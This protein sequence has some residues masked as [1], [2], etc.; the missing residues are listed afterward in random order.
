[1]DSKQLLAL[2]DLGH[3]VTIYPRG[4]SF[5]RFAP[6]FFIDLREIMNLITDEVMETREDNG[7][8][9]NKEYIRT[10]FFKNEN[11]QQWNHL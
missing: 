2:F 10:F 1:M 5:T 3:R 7:I 6:F 9:P 11:W 8:G 4:I